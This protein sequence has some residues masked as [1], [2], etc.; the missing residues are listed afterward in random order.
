[1]QISLLLKEYVVIGTHLYS[2]SGVSACVWQSTAK[3]VEIR[4]FL[5]AYE[6]N[7]T[8]N[9]VDHKN[10]GNKMQQLT[11]FC[12]FVCLFGVKQRT[13]QCKLDTTNSELTTTYNLVPHDVMTS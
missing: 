10:H 13:T 11:Y 9:H 8:H 3:M 7:R 4:D 6:T 2:L 5:L 1:M 12:I